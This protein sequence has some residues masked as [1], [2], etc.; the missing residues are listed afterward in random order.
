MSTVFIVAGL[1]Y[2]D[3][4]K[5]QTVHDLALTHDAKLVVR[6]NGG[7]QAGH[8]VIY[9]GRHHTFSQ[10]GAAS[11][12]PNVETHLSQF[13]VFNPMALM[14]EVRHLSVQTNRSEGDLL[15]SLTVDE[16]ALVVTPFHRWVN[17]LKETAR[18][19]DRHGSCGMGIGECVADSIEHAPE[20]LRAGD[21]TKDE[22]TIRNKLTS[23]YQL[24]LKKTDCEIMMGSINL[25][26]LTAKYKELGARIKVVSP[27]FLSNYFKLR[28]YNTVVFEGAQG[29]LLDETYGFAP[30]HTWSDCTFAKAK[31]MLRDAG[32][33]GNI[34]QIGLLRA[35]TTRHGAGP[36]VTEDPFLTEYIHDPFNVEGSWQG[37]FRVG[38]FDLVAAKY[39]L[40]CAGMIDEVRVNC[41]KHLPS[42][43]VICTNYHYLS[44]TWP[45]PSK[46][47]IPFVKDPT[48]KNQEDLAK[49]LFLAKSDYG[50]IFQT[51]PWR[52]ASGYGFQQRVGEWLTRE[53]GVTTK[54]T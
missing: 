36:M 11:L 20:V 1:L 17:Q 42:R 7:P 14:N 23:T 54:L 22:G 3:E 47:L 4:G 19:R 27:S 44:E 25:D 29:I 8:N 30:F 28:P 53:L 52:V 13:M 41:W 34:M 31:L 15:A 35:Y 6:Y 37:K 9:N 21:L 10:F 39:A 5:G 33:C 45:R 43:M 51:D 46:G 38:N 26:E 18:G 50:Q 32:F 48:L 16:R 24:Q 12:L 49:K 2:G 40:E